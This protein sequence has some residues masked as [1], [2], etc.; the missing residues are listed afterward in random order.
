MARALELSYL[1]SKNG[2]SKIGAELGVANGSTL[3]HL[4][5]HH[6]ELQVIAVD[7]YKAS[8]GTGNKKSTGYCPYEQ[9]L[10]NQVRAL[11]ERKA[12]TYGGRCRLIVEDTTLA[13]ESV[14]DGVL[15]FIFI[16]A[17]HRTSFVRSDIA[18]WTPKVRVGGMIAGHDWAFP[19]VR[20][21]LDALYGPFWNKRK[22]IWYVFNG[23]TQTD[24]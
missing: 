4:L 14:K 18:V 19:S 20:K 21:V 22:D 8:Q 6:P 5:D 15:D 16:D 12:N 7:S 1:I 10:Q 23:G 11:V 17:D 9:S 2:A 24:V 13:A 3:F